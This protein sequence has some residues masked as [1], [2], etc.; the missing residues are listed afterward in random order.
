MEAVVELIAT[1]FLF[2]V[3]DMGFKYLTVTCVDMGKNYNKLL[4][5]NLVV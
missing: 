4:T 2:L 3:C 5:E 1:Q